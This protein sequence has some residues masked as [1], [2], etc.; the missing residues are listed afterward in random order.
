M[1]T[2]SL[3]RL[4][5]PLFALMR[6]WV[7]LML[8]LA[9]APA[10]AL[11]ALQLDDTQ[12]SLSAWP[13]ITHLAEGAAGLSLAEV[14]RRRV[15]FLPPTG[16]TANLGV[17][18]EAVW[19][20]LPLQ[21]GRGDGRWV[22]DINFPLLK[23]VD[24]HLVQHG[25]VLSSTRLGNG[26][27]F[28][29]RPLP[30][31]A[32]AVALELQPG[33]A[34]ELYLRVSTDSAMLLPITLSKAAVFY[35]QESRE[36]LLQ[37]LLAGLGL[38]L[39]T[40]SLMN[41][42]SLRDPMFLYYAL[43]LAST[44]SMFIA[45]HGLAHQYVW[46]E[47][48]GLAAKLAPLSA[49]VAIATGSRF[50][51][52]ALGARQ[53]RPG[54]WRSLQGLTLLA[55]GAF[56]ASAA[57]WLDYRST[58][59]M[60]A[61]LGPLP[62]LVALPLVSA[63]ARQGEPAAVLMGLGWCA[64]TAGALVMAGLL[65]GHLP[66]NFWTQH[67]FQ[68]ATLL[69]MLIWTRIL[70]LRIQGLRRDAER[71]GPERLAL[72]AQAQTD[73]LTGLPNRR[74]LQLALALALPQC[75]PDSVL[76]V[77]VLDLD[78]FKPINDRWGHDAGD[79]LLIQVGKRLRALLRHGD[80]VARIGGDEF[81]I[82]TPGITDERQA[83]ALGRKVLDAFRLPFEVQGQACQVG[84]SIGFALAPHDGLQAADLLKRADAAMYTG[85]QAGGHCLHRGGASMAL[86]GV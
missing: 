79:A 33:Q 46:S 6:A 50:A 78:D 14:M 25:R 5:T 31:R 51:A 61:L 45:Y 19:L 86:S 9:I 42:L 3:A 30:T 18:R 57:G 71:A 60:A 38:A 85:K 63:Q 10:L 27:P 80:L 70:S 62:L 40:Y 26:M 72:L 48:D 76:A 55:A 68:L 7:G 16:P 11:P 73:A 20:L 29:Q 49:L 44:G 4:C 8:C 15:D 59:L 41:W 58:Q 53:H 52:L 23:Q 74:G 12:P 1:P 65:R 17:R 54:V 82:M 81:V 35:A 39:L 43:M 2:R 34:Y 13:S 77:Y 24:L 37:G 56:V 36:Q 64:Y 67:G 47:L 21:L 32:H 83:L 84:L 75:R 66:V 22:L 69:E 28:D